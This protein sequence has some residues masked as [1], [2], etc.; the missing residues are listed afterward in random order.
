MNLIANQLRSPLRLIAAICLLLL[1]PLI[2][3]TP[4]AAAMDGHYP[5]HA[6]HM[7]VNFDCAAACA[8]AATVPPTQ[9]VI[10]ENE[11]RTPD[12][13]P[14]EIVAYHL[15]F[16]S[17]YIPKV[18]RPN[19]LYNTSPSRPPDIVKMSAHFRF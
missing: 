2:G 1:L 4:R 7:E 9:A 5:T 12:P 8:R 16:Q 11:T 6:E 3:I 17:L 14:Q 10:N 18:Q 19:P 13:E 15:Q